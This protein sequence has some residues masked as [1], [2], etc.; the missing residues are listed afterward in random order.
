MGTKIRAYCLTMWNKPAMPDNMKWVRYMIA[1]REICPDTK[2]EHWQ[3]YIELHR[4]QRITTIKKFFHDEKIHLEERKG[5]R[6]EARDYCMK[7]KDYQEYGVWNKLGQ[8]CRVDLDYL[9]KKLI[10]GNSN[11]KEVMTEQPGLYCRYRNGLK[12][13]Y[14]VGQKNASKDFR[15]VK[16]EVIWGDTGAGKTRQATSQGDHFMLDMPDTGQPLWFDGYNGEK[17][18][19]LDDF[20]GRIKHSKLL[21]LLNGNQYRCAIKGGFTY[22]RWNKIT[23]TSNAAPE[24]WYRN[25]IH[26]GWPALSR[27]I[28][29]VTNLFEI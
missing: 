21:R 23:I 8:G 17:H 16:V 11:L 4:P 25:M 10:S 19:I 3:C 22:A 6:I 13:M 9:A 28:N 29:K 5:T 18:I 24:T 12:D 15:K 2:K 7:D 26:D 1:G 27:R 14:A 20:Y